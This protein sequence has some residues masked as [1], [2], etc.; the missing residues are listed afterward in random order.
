M[1]PISGQLDA[2]ADLIDRCT[3]YAASLLQDIY[4]DCVREIPVRLSPA[5]VGDLSPLSMPNA[6]GWVL[7][8]SL[9][10]PAPAIT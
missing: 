3:R 8:K 1:Q 9:Q 10:D 2:F 5:V 4:R 6:I 7:G